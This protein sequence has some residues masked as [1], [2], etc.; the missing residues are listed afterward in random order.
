M[1]SARITGRVK[2]ELKVEP[3]ENNDVRWWLEKKGR[4]R[5]S[6]RRRVLRWGSG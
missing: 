3:K 6:Q 5:G 1:K 4:D 2:S